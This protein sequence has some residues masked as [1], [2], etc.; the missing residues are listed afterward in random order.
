MTADS[1]NPTD[2]IVAPESYDQRFERMFG[3]DQ[4]AL[5]NSYMLGGGKKLAVSTSAAFFQLYLN[6]CD[7][8]EIHALNKGFPLEAI[9]Y[10]IVYH[11]WEKQKAEYLVELQKGVREQLIKANLETVSLLSNMLAVANKQHGDKLKKYLQTGDPAD[12]QGTIV[13]DSIHQLIKAIE[14]LQ[15][16]TGQDDKKN[17]GGAVTI[18]GNVGT[19]N[20]LQVS[21]EV[22]AKELAALAKAKRVSKP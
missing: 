13:V 1:P 5:V 16:I 9:L 14:G 4:F 22:A 12:L 8:H 7:A 21:P 17:E 6:G 18:Q 10:E 19:I 20:Q 11:D 15:K 3:R 2:L